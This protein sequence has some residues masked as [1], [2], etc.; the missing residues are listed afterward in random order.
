MF[1]KE[2]QEKAVNF[3][4]F[5]TWLQHSCF[6]I[7]RPGFISSVEKKFKKLTFDDETHVVQGV[8][9]LDH[10][11]SWKHIN[12]LVCTYFLKNRKSKSTQSY[13]CKGKVGDYLEKTRKQ[14]KALIDTLFRSDPYAIVYKTYNDGIEDIEFAANANHYRHTG[15]Q[16]SYFKQY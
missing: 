12:Q 2:K 7:S 5:N 8:H 1:K 11:L 9:S 10:V 4:G 3:N 14:I 13:T 6:G 15:K 16:L